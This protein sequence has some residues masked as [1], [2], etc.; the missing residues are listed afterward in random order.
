[1]DRNWNGLNSV[2][3]NSTDITSDFDNGTLS[4]KIAANDFSGYDLGMQIK[5]TLTIDDTNYAASI[6]FAHANACYGYDA[7]S[8]TRT[9][10]IG[11]VVY[12]PGYA[13]IW[14]ES[15]TSGGYVSSTF[16]T[17]TQKIV[18]ALVTTLGAGHMISRTVILS[19][20]TTNGTS[21]SW[22]W[23]S[24][25]YGE[26]LSAAQ[27]F[28]IC[29]GSNFR[30][31]GDTYEQLALFK[32]VRPNQVFSSAWIYLR[33]VLSAGSAACLSSPGTISNSPVADSH[34]IA[35]FILLK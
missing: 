24:D 17:N 19:S 1:M 21:S 15:N 5:K 12:L 30:D 8:M 10:N 25:S 6:I 26:A 32:L 13:T 9:P 4:A 27:M 16:R 28:G 11:C 14:N 7:Y 18:Q 31:V 20:A 2:Y 23:V 35:L 22:T 3:Y 34:G 29:A 33:D